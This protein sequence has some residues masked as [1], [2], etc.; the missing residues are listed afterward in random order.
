MYT[1][2][3]GTMKD[4]NLLKSCEQELPE[5]VNTKGGGSYRVSRISFSTKKDATIKEKPHSE[6]PN[7]L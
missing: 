5:N 7:Y 3:E 1:A 4:W 6:I 2:Y